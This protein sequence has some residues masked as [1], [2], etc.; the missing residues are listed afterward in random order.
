MPYSAVPYKLGGPRCSCAVQSII[1]YRFSFDFVVHICLFDVLLRYFRLV[2]LMVRRLPP[3]E[4]IVGSS[5]ILVAF[6]QF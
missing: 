5:P 3:K 6:F 1:I 4:K 2:G